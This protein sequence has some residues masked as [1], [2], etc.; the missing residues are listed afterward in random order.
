MPNKYICL[1]DGGRSGSIRLTDQL[2][3]EV[4][5][6]TLAICSRFW[7]REHFYRDDGTKFRATPADGASC[8]VS[9]LTK[10]LA[11]IL[12]NPFR[13]LAF[14][15]ADVGPFQLDEIKAKIFRYL[16]VDGDIL[17]Q[18]MDGDEIRRRL[19]RIDSFAGLVDLIETMQ[20]K[21]EAG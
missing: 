10:L 13:T 19:D 20:G 11:H 21:N 4:R 14:Q 9:G 1:Y 7:E 18:F 8:G 17:T 5:A 6:N 15:Y 12:Y 3:G 2:P 16:E